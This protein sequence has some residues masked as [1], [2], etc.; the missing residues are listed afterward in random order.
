MYICIALSEST[1]S[2]NATEYV[3]IGLVTSRDTAIHRDELD[4][5]SHL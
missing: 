5:L 4:H 3:I 1:K 2:L